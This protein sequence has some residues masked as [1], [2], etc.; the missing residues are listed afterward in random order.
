MDGHVVLVLVELC[1][2]L[3]S[4]RAVGFGQRESPV[5]QGKTKFF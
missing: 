1:L 2:K 3:R 5:V 4:K